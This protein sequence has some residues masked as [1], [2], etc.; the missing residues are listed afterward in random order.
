[1][2]GHTIQIETPGACTQETLD[3]TE[4]ELGNVQNKREPHSLRLLPLVIKC[5]AIH[6][7]PDN[8]FTSSIRIALC[9]MPE[10]FSVNPAIL[11]LSKW[12]KSIVNSG[13]FIKKLVSERGKISA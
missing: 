8:Y 3:Y 11:P 2:R 7:S 13:T 9:C 4:E 12:L 5:A 6:T 10:L 1:V